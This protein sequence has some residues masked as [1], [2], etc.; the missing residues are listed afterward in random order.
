[1]Y[2]YKTWKKLKKKLKLRNTSVKSIFGITNLI[3]FRDLKNAPVLKKIFFSMVIC[4]KCFEHSVVFPADLFWSNLHLN[5]F[6]KKE[7]TDLLFQINI[8]WSLF[9]GLI[10][11]RGLYLSHIWTIYIE[12]KCSGLYWLY[13]VSLGFTFFFYFS[14][15]TLNERFVH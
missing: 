5:N 7:K 11:W 9:T 12:S 14:R 10:N 1:M 6:L 4:C 2:K 15:V 13:C 8:A 3:Y